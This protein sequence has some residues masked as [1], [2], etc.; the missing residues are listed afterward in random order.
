MEQNSDLTVS[1]ILPIYNVEPDFL[2]K[3]FTSL[4]DQTFH[5]A[6]YLMVD[7][8]SDP[9]VEEICR[10]YCCDERFRFIR[11]DHSGVSDARN[12]GIESSK[13]KYLCFV[14]P[15]DWV[16]EGYLEVLVSLIGRT[17]SD[18]GV[19]DAYVHYEKVSRINH[20]LGEE[21]TVILEGTEKNRLLYQ[22]IGK[23]ICSY[24]PPEIAAGVPWAKIFR[25]QFLTDKKIRFVSGMPRMQDNIFCLYAYEE[26]NTVSYT[27]Q[28]LYHY[29][30]NNSSA[31]HSYNPDIIS[32]FEMYYAETKK[33]LDLHQKEAVLYEA[34]YMKE[35]TSFNSYFTYYFFSGH[36]KT[37]RQ[38]CREIDSVLD[39]EPYRTA[40]V[41]ISRKYLSAS[42]YMFVTALK[43][44]MYGLLRVLVT[45]RNHVI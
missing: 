35:L 39:R 28:L 18:I 3:C 2:E 16:D 22:L 13:G 40:L 15:D 20:F 42:E 41:H 5:D 44:H 37:Y 6:E 14:D 31:S 25:K 21:G 34:L 29:R 17:N 27:P 32:H 45:I 7:D 38:A 1:V 9:Y 23:K 10:Q 33:F 12:L 36:K 11:K 30:K 26:A 4:K 43:Y 24:Y 8:G 19:T